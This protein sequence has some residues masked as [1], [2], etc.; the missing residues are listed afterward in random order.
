[1]SNNRNTSWREAIAPGLAIQVFGVLLFLF[2]LALAVNTYYTIKGERFILHQQLDREGNNLAEASAIFATESLLIEDYPVLGTYT[3]NLVSRH[4]DLNHILIK[5]LDLKTVAKASRQAKNTS[6]IKRYFSQVRVDENLIGSIEIGISTENRDAVIASHLKKMIIQSLL[7]FLTLAV[8]LFIFFRKRITDPI[9]SLVDQAKNLSTGNISDPIHVQASGE[10]SQ[11]SLALDNMRSRLKRSYDEITI[12]NQLLD[13][14]VAERTKELSDTN[15]KLV[16]THS[17]LL[18]SEKM[19]AI[20]QLSAG[21]AHEINNPIGFVTSNISILSDWFKT[22]VKIVQEYDNQTDSENLITAFQNIQTS[23]DFAYIEKEIPL[24]IKE[25]QDGLNRVSTIVSDLK[26][27]AHADDMVWLKS[28]L[29][30]VLSSTLNIVRNEVKYKANIVLNTDNA[31]LVECLPAQINQVFM[32]IIVNAAQ[33]IEGM[34][35]ITITITN[36]DIW[37]CV[38]IRDTGNG[39][40]ENDLNR[41]IEPFYTTKPVGQGTGLGLSISYEIINTHHG[42][43]EIESRVGEGTV[44]HIWL[45]LKQPQNS[46]E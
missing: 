16:E 32:N 6:N 35:T 18:Q 22:L 1:M 39:I 25:T 38:S 30:E 20:G 33:A 3:G 36:T 17:Q 12:Q 26:N 15:Q 27:F 9:H 14:R 21:V 11:L 46:Q 34:G 40:P 44:F 28:D 13:Q 24:L 31:P 23:N 4:P 29:S 10:L 45:P 5:R 2:A 8:S 7:I 19:A 42:R 37:A 43:L 41:V